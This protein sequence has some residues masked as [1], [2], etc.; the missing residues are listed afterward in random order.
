MLDS[1][2]KLYNYEKKF[3]NNVN[4]TFNPKKIPKNLQKFP[5]L[6]F[7]EFINEIK[8]V[9]S[10]KLTPKELD[11]WQEYF[12]EQKQNQSDLLSLIIKTEEEINSI[13]YDLYNLS[14]DEIMIIEKS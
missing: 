13:V 11:D 5:N 3:L 9:S 7:N 4:S 10:V 8:S 2:I 6:E 1:K 14:K 12:D